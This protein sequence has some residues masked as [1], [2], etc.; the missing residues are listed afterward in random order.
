MR[1]KWKKMVGRGDKMRGRSYSHG[2][3]PS[4]SVPSEWLRV[5]LL[6]SAAIVRVFRMVGWPVIPPTCLLKVRTFRPPIF[7]QS[8]LRIVCTAHSSNSQ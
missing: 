5:M 2:L 6:H 3:M 7:P 4:D 8:L 1:R